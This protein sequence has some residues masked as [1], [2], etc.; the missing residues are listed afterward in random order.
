MHQLH[1]EWLS[2]K[3]E[4]KNWDGSFFRKVWLTLEAVGKI[5]QLASILGIFN[6]FR[7]VSFTRYA[8]RRIEF[9]SLKKCKKQ[10][11]TSAYRKPNCAPSLKI[12]YS[13]FHY[14]SFHLDVL[15]FF[16]KQSHNLTYAYDVSSFCAFSSV[17]VS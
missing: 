4:S 17:Y 11:T 9:V 6:V 15:E 13:T 8:I 2:R 3:E 7:A 16:P 10:R 1:V 12:Y 14:L 5:P